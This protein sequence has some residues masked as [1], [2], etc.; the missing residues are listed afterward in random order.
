MTQENKQKEDEEVI[1]N[2]TDVCDIQNNELTL[3]RRIITYLLEQIDKADAEND[4]LQDKVFKLEKRTNE[5]EKDRDVFAKF[6][7]FFLQER[8]LKREDVEE[9]L[10]NYFST[11]NKELN[12]NSRSFLQKYLDS[13]R[14]A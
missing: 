13:F 5:D 6:W 1:K 11:R 2:L 4:L 12:G 7:K 14:G 10:T 8:D 9:S 3:N